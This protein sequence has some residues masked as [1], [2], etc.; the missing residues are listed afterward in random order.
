MGEF[1]RSF[2]KSETKLADVVTRSSGSMF[3][4]YLHVAWFL[5]WVLFSKQIGDPFPYGLLTMLVSLEAIFLST[6]ILVSQNRQAELAEE[7]A[8][9]ED[10]EEEEQHEDIQESFEDLQDEFDDLQKDL[11][12][13]KKLVEKIETRRSVE[14][15]H[16]L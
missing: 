8:Q 15:S 16:T 4:A 11:E 3:F 6:F 2:R 5:L 10:K 13:I 12:D 14:R 9:E 1:K 7:R